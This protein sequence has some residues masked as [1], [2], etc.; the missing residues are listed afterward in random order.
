MSTLFLVVLAVVNG[1]SLLWLLLVYRDDRSFA[2][3]QLWV[4]GKDNARWV[5]TRLF[6]FFQMSYLLVIVLLSVFSV[7]YFLFS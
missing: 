1:V 3:G 2:R 5:R 7:F 6:F 4:L